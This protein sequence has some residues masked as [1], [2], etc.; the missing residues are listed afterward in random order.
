MEYRGK[1]DTKDML[2]VNTFYFE[3]NAVD[4]WSKDLGYS[5]KCNLGIFIASN[6]N[7]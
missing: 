6:T 2:P 3:C 5:H 1:K 4:G 7:N